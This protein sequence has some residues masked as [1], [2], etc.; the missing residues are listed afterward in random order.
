MGDLDS[1]VVLGSYINYSWIRAAE[2]VAGKHRR[3]VINYWLALSCVLMQYVNECPN[4]L[5]I[6]YVWLHGLPSYPD[7]PGGGGETGDCL[8]EI[9]V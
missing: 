7:Q 1:A 8:D 9:V 6:Q 3:I 2:H 4:K 5:S